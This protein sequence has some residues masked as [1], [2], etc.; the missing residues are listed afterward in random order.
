MT[1]GTV[2]EQVTI[3][4]PQESP[5]SA[6]LVASLKSS[7]LEVERVASIRVEGVTLQT[8]SEVEHENKT[9]TKC[10]LLRQRKKKKKQDKK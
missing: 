2:E 9:S 1:Q 3:T 8:L 6:T 7:G 5:Y 4:T 10:L